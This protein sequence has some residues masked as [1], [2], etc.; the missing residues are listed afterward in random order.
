MPENFGRPMSYYL[1]GDS[2]LKDWGKIRTA[3][4]E[5][6]D[7]FAIELV[8][9]FDYD[10]WDD[11][12][13]I[14]LKT[15]GQMDGARLGMADAEADEVVE[16][17]AEL[18]ELALKTF[19]KWWKESESSF[20]SQYGVWPVEEINPD[21]DEIRRVFRTG[22]VEAY[23]KAAEKVKR[24]EYA[25]TSEV[26]SE[27]PNP[28]AARAMAEIGDIEPPEPEPEIQ[29]SGGSA[30]FNDPNYSSMARGIQDV[31]VQRGK[32]MASGHYPY[33]VIEDVGELRTFANDD[34]SHWWST[35]DGNDVFERYLPGVRRIYIPA[36][37]K[38]YMESVDG[39][40][41]NPDRWRNTHAL[42]QEDVVVRIR[43]QNQVDDGATY[44]VE[45]LD[46]ERMTQAVSFGITVKNDGA[47]EIEEV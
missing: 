41:V 1:Q 32:D 46:S 29:T 6:G 16:G 20:T 14:G 37:V 5:E 40:S 3:A 39:K 22:F 35:L 23:N 33:A 28:Y 12:G 25:S 26:I 45:F 47:V 18:K 10:P 34:C 11:E 8:W 21:L 15:A 9:A 17:K 38:S 24:G 4:K 13:R 36:F 31:A 43:T 2:M 19:D 7:L 27:L 44:T 42:E 30:A